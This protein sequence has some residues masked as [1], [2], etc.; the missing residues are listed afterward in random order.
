M[1]AAVWAVLSPSPGLIGAPPMGCGRCPFALP[2]VRA[3]L[4]STSPARLRSQR[5]V[6]AEVVER[7]YLVLIVVRVALRLDLVDGQATDLHGGDHRR[8]PG[9]ALCATPRAGSRRPLGA[10]PRRP[11]APARCT[12]PS[13]P[14]R[15]PRPRAGTAAGMPRPRR[16]PS[17]CAPL[18]PRATI[19]KRPLRGVAAAVPLYFIMSRRRVAVVC[20]PMWRDP[21]PEGVHRKGVHRLGFFEAVAGIRRNYFT[22]CWE[23][24]P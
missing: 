4:F 15:R 7:E 24:A 1:G 22:A 3:P 14:R 10:G 16:S 21:C 17:T 2:H 5:P 12:P 19:Q 13:T 23:A 11:R 9:V 20:A 18:P 8:A 6:V